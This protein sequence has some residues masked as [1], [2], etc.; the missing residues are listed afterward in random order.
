MDIID[1]AQEMAELHRQQLLS[2]ALSD[3]YRKRE[4]PLIIDGVRCCLS[5]K[6][7]IP[8]ERLRV[9]PNAVRCTA[10]QERK[11]RLG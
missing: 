3:R 1:K 4:T 9:Q 7:P 10:C 11:D 6:D 8:K 2:G 5:C